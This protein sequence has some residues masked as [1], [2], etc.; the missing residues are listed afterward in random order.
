MKRDWFNRKTTGVKS[1]KLPAGTP[2][3]CAVGPKERVVTKKGKFWIP[4]SL[5]I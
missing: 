1:S 2:P 4:I 5:G 3:V